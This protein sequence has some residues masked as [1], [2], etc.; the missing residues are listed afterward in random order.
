[1][2]KSEKRLQGTRKAKGNVIGDAPIADQTAHGAKALPGPRR[3]SRHRQTNRPLYRGAPN[4]REPRRTRS[5][6]HSESSSVSGVGC[7]W[8]LSVGSWREFAVSPRSR[9]A[10][11][12]RALLWGKSLI[13][14]LSRRSHAW[15]IGDKHGYHDASGHHHRVP[16]S[17]RRRLLR[18]GALVLGSTSQAASP[19]TLLNGSPCSPVCAAA[20]SWSADTPV[21]RNPA[22]REALGKSQLRSCETHNT[23]TNQRADDKWW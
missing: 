16:S 17:G 22:P 10:G 21:Y 15:A 8:L 18:P 13:A 4:H 6:S 9:W 7:S 19:P 11:L 3:P 12:A 5:H 14:P 20:A 1:M 2:H 23:Q